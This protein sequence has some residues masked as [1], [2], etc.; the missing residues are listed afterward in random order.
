MLDE[1]NCWARNCK[2]YLGV[3]Q[4]DGTEMTEVNYCK[5]YPKGIPEDIAYGD[6][7]HLKVQSD[8][9]GNFVYEEDQP[10]EF[11]EELEED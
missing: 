6:N 3:L 8:Q 5:A 11:S 4:P 2:H 10:R 9:V 7:E 1:P